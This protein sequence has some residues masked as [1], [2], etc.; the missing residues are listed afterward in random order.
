[1]TGGDKM[2]I[3]IKMINGEEFKVSGEQTLQEFMT[4]HVEI[5]SDYLKINVEE[6]GTIPTVLVKENVVSIQEKQEPKRARM[7]QKPEGW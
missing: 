1:M 2:T 7:V 4:E 5:P 3:F 6:R